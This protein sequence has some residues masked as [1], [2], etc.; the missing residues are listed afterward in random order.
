[1]MGFLYTRLEIYF[2]IHL[3]I[4]FTNFIA[5]NCVS[6]RLNSTQ[7]VNEERNF[8]FAWTFHYYGNFS[9]YHFIGDSDSEKYFRTEYQEERGF[10]RSLELHLLSFI[11]LIYY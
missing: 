5:E 3:E 1:M 6:Y 8:C 7:F 11:C 10:T 2:T 4:L 9:G